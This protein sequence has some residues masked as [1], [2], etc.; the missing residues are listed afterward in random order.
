[1]NDKQ[2]AKLLKKTTA[3]AEAKHS[4]VRPA[5]AYDPTLQNRDEDEGTEER[6]K[7]FEEMRKREF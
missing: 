7:M 5:K 3:R 4:K 1:M 6:S 2:L